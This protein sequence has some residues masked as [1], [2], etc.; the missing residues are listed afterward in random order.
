MTTEQMITE[1]FHDF[2]HGFNAQFSRFK[3]LTTHA[4]LPESISVLML[5]A[6]AV[7]DFSQRV[8]I[9][10]AAPSA[11]Y[12]VNP[13]DSVKDMLQLAQYESVATVLLQCD[14]QR[15]HEVPLRTL[16][17]SSVSVPPAHRNEKRSHTPRTFNS[18]TRDQNDHSKNVSP[19]K[20]CRNYRH[21]NGDQNADGSLPK[22]AI[23]SSCSFNGDKSTHTNAAS[24]ANAKPHNGDRVPKFNHPPIKI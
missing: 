13:T 15:V 23:N 2:G 1:S 14:T 19:C 16:R 8:P 9:L 11:A 6:N 18:M 7:V 4:A 22:D 17:S 21:G 10:A 5:L 24:T 12:L 20:R 3:K